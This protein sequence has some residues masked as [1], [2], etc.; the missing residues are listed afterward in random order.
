MRVLS[1]DKAASSL[2]K[3]AGNNGVPPLEW[4]ARDMDVVQNKCPSLG[5]LTERVSYGY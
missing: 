2:Q 4:H 5:R 3:L 1:Q